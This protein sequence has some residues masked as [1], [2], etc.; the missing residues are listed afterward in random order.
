LLF[1]DEILSRGFDGAHFIAGLSEHFRNLLV[2]KDQSTL[3]LLEV[4][5]GIKSKYLQQSQ[6]GQYRSC[7][8][9]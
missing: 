7:F 9:P 3:K 8:R 2:S 1:F 5:E 4:S 6:A